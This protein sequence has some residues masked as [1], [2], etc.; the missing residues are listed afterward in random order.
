MNALKYMGYIHS[1]VSLEYHLYGGMVLELLGAGA[2]LLF[3]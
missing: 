1:E 3:L 2:D